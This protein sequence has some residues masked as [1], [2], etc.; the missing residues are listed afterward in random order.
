M[1]QLDFFTFS[2]Q[3]LFLILGFSGLYYFNLLVLFPRIWWFECEKIFFLKFLS[4]EIYFYDRWALGLITMQLNSYRYFLLE[5]WIWMYRLVNYILFQNVSFE[6]YENS[7]IN[8]KNLLIVGLLSA[9]SF[10]FFFKNILIFNA[11]KLMFIYFCLVFIIIVITTK[12]IFVTFFK[13]DLKKVMTSLV[14]M[15][16]KTEGYI[17]RMKWLSVGMTIYILGKTKFSVFLNLLK[18]KQI[19]LQNVKI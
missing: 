15:E 17:S 14:F 8:A 1:P 13:D 18:C 6:N 11:E 7:L 9:L 5:N 2:H 10:L 12:K 3:F 19:K 4:F 16:D